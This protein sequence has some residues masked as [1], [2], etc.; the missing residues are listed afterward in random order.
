MEVTMITTTARLEEVSISPVS[1]VLLIKKSAEGS[2]GDTVS[3]PS[4]GEV[5]FTITVTGAIA[6]SKVTVGPPSSVPAKLSWNAAVT[7]TNIVTIR[8]HNPTT[9]DI[10]VV[11]GTWKVDVWE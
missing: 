11:T 2:S 6:G 4:L 10:S 5:T 9:S 7:A 8:L 3:V 1:Q